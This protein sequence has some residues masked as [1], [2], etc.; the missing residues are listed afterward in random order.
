MVWV[1]EAA[2]DWKR[3]RYGEGVAEE[4]GGLAGR[5]RDRTGDKGTWSSQWREKNGL[6]R[7]WEVGFPTGPPKYLTGPLPNEQVKT[8]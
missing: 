8:P 6:F 5:Q 1:P 3:S 4:K 2:E 7:G